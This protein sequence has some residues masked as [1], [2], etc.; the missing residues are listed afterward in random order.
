ML[1]KILTLSLILAT[2][3]NTSC[4]A[5]K[6]KKQTKVL[7]S[8]SYGD[9]KIALYNETPKHRDNFIQLVKDGFYDGT[10]FHRVIAGFM[11]Q[12]G[13]PDSKTAPAGK[14]LGQGGPGYTIPA[15]FNSSLIHKKGALAAARTGG[16]SNPEKESS[17]SQFYLV[18]GKKYTRD[19]LDK[20][21]AKINRK[22][23]TP[24]VYTEEQYKIYEEVG[25][26]P[27]LDGDYTVYGEVI[28]GLDVIDKI[29]VVKKN[30]ANRPDGDIKMTMKIIR[31]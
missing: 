20:F 23:T 8:T 11:I 26:V 5:Q 19:E 9:I 31:K 14:A 29:A 7:L 16:P 4:L 12:G 25:G 22:R 10:L 27:F 30:R 13:D 17:G 6:G 15:E 21:L 2:L 24:L 1:K 28:E 18:Q 3:F